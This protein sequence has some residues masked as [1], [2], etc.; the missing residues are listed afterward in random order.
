MIKRP[1]QLVS[2]Q[3]HIMPTFYMCFVTQRQLLDKRKGVI[4]RPYQLVPIQS[5][6]MPTFYMCFANRQL[7]K[8]WKATS[9]AREIIA[10]IRTSTQHGSQ[11]T[12]PALACQSTYYPI[13][14]D[15]FW[16]DA[17]RTC[18]VICLYTSKSPL[19][20]RTQRYQRNGE[21]RIAKE[22]ASERKHLS[23]T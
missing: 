5:H 17:A 7:L 3:S 16:V 18:F 15:R 1:C 22:K 10:R 12:K 13:P 2:I 4:K 11:P 8:S 19:P 9:Y 23:V 20:V 6:I 21:R 14:K